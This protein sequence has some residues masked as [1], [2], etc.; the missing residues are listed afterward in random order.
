MDLIELFQRAATANNGR[1]S[2]LG[3]PKSL[4][5]ENEQEHFKTPKT[6]LVKHD[7]MI[8]QEQFT[9]GTSAST[10]VAKL[11][12]AGATSACLNLNHIIC[13]STN[14]PHENKLLF[15]RST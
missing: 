7:T 11:P 10:C 6:E 8:P 12:E 4:Q 2:K 14:K 3:F 5:W 13:D 1:K 9:K 15:G